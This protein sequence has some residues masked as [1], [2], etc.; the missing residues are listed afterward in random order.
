MK[1]DSNRMP[2]RYFALLCDLLKADGLDVDDMLRSAEI[3][4]TQIYGPDASISLRQFEVLVAKLEEGSGRSD[5]GLMLGRQVKLSTHEILGY[6]LLTSPTLDYAL[7]L[8]S[9]YYRIITPTF[10]LQYCRGPKTSELLFRPALPLGSRA[11]RFL[12]ETIMVSTHETLQ[13][14][15][16]GQLPRCGIYVSYPRPHYAEH[17]ECLQPANIYFGYEDSPGVRFVLD[18]AA[19]SQRLPLA[20][21]NSLKMAE[22]RCE[23]LVKA[24]SEVLQM[25]E[26]VEMMLLESSNGF[27]TL[28][29]LAKLVNQSPRTLDRQLSKE[30]SHFLELSK[31]I[32]HKKACDLLKTSGQAISQIAFQLG[33]KEVASFS[34]A[35]KRESGCSPSE[36]QN[37]QT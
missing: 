36:F 24:T 17:Y 35:F 15:S 9:R 32:R 4:P 16:H 11:L 28:S 12:L 19:L 14:L 25:T 26:W 10:R 5:L 1:S 21:K 23:Q 13:T 6:A 3:W 27:P 37:R 7:S 22:A 8:A 30:G 2:A 20:D 18:S 31:R 34:R 29:E 33:Y